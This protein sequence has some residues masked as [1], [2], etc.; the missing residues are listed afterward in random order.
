MSKRL[1]IDDQWS[2]NSFSIAAVH[3]G[4]WY[5]SMSRSSVCPKSYSPSTCATFR[6]GVVAPCTSKCVTIIKIRSPSRSGDGRMFRFGAP[7]LLPPP[8]PLAAPAPSGSISSAAAARPARAAST[9]NDDRANALAAL[10]SSS[11]IGR[12][13]DAEEHDDDDED[14]EDDDDEEDKE[15]E[16]DE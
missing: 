10:F 5:T 9:P 3:S 15:N 13:I 4:H 6:N 11:A 12:P 7:P 1:C 16:E 2:S 8:P 14:E